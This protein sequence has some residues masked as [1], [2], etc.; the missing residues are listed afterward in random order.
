MQSSS[1]SF[2]PGIQQSVSWC[3]TL[4]RLIKRYWGRFS[5]R[6]ICYKKPMERFL[7]NRTVAEEE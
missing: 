4:Y 6:M 7:S 5:V 3:H 2:L 1:L